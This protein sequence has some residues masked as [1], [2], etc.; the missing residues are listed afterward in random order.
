MLRLM[1]FLIGFYPIVAHVGV[2]T[3]HARL[4]VG[5]LIVLLL[6]VLLY[7]PRNRELRNII[8]SST[9]LLSAA[10]LAVFDLDYLLIY[11]PPVIVP[12]IL[13]MIF[14]ESLRYGQIPLITQFALNTEGNLNDE[15]K[16][17]T[18]HVTQLWAWIF[19]FMVL[20]A[21]VLAIFSPIEIWSWVSYIGNYFL[22]AFI[23]I[24]EFIYRKHRFKSKNINLKKF[25]AALVKYRWK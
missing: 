5:Y 14:S 13:L 18:R 9:I 7:P 3:A 17:Y 15:E 11:L 21:I 1:G 24:T 16:I 6:L 2:W 10:A 8:I 22:I 12:G 23:L 19:A 20:D 4:A 25:I